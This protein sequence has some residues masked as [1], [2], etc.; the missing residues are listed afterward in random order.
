[1]PSY[2]PD[3]EVLQWSRDRNLLQTTTIEKQGFKLMEE[4]GEFCEGCLKEKPEKIRDSLGDMFVVLVQL[5][6]LSL[7]ESLSRC[8]WA[9][10][11]EIK[12]RRGKMVNGSFIK[13]EDLN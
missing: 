7:G 13:E 10:Y 6:E 3:E 5:A 2:F 1:M 4:L 12:D 11:D 8:A 9:A